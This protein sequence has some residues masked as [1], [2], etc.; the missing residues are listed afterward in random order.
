MLRYGLLA[1]IFLGGVVSLAFVASFLVNADVVRRTVTVYISSIAGQ[2][3]TVRGPGTF[4]L[5]PLPT[6]SV[7]TVQVGGAN[8]AT[9]VLEAELITGRLSLI[10]LM[11]GRLELTGLSLV[12]PRFS[13]LVDSEGRANWRSG[14]SFLSLFVPDNDGDKGP[15]LGDVEITGGQLIYRDDRAKRSGEISDI[16]IRISWPLIGSGLT[17]LGKFSL[18]GQVV[19]FHGVLERPSALFRQDISPFELSFTMP[20]MSAKIS[21]NALAGRDVHLEGQVNFSSPT[22]RMLSRWLVPEVQNAPDFGP[23]GGTAQLTIIDRVMKLSNARIAGAGSQGEGTL[24]FG[25]GATRTSL[26]G[27]MDFDVLNLRPLLDV[28]V[29]TKKTSLGVR[30]ETERIGPIDMDLR[31]SVAKLNLG[32]NV[33]QRAAMSIFSREGRVEASIGDGAVFGGKIS[34]RLT[35][36]AMSGGRV[37]T[38]ATLALSN[39]QIDDALRA[40]VGFTKLTGIGSLG[41]DVSGE[42]KNFDEV[43]HTL[44]GEGKIGLVSGV[45]AGFDIASLARRLDRAVPESLGDARG[46][47]TAIETA[48]ATFRISEGIATTQDAIIRGTGYRVALKGNIDTRAQNLALDGTISPQLGSD[49]LRAFELPFTVRGPWIDPA[50]ALSGDPIL[51]RPQPSVSPPSAN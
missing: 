34:G 21:G 12:K 19:D 31:L 10:S 4:S 39:I 3:V 35:T 26:Q 50:I 27:T 5:L 16:N 32:G 38:R 25:F 2:D 42:G 20:A 43:L 6:V 1:G 28:Q 9:N 23:I 8:G 29:P 44:T 22:L 51:R 46:G 40:T 45:A 15:R 24:E 14:A 47:R 30:I 36:L 33:I 11:A 7:S 41:F 13:F 37:A 49:T 18:R 48:T 17:G